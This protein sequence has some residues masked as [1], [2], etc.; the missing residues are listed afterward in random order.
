MFQFKA[1]L[2]MHIVALITNGAHY[3]LKY[4]PDT[5]RLLVIPMKETDQRLLQ[6]EWFRNQKDTFDFPMQAHCKQV[7]SVVDIALTSEEQSMI[8]H[9]VKTPGIG[10]FIEHHG[11]Y[12]N[13]YVYCSLDNS[14]DTPHESF[15]RN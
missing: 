10:E 11:W 14:V 3:K 6:S 9:V 12:D 8:D 4:F 7:N 5:K 2:P 13:A 15:V 1:L